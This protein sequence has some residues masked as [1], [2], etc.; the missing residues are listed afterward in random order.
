MSFDKNIFQVLSHYSG[1]CENLELTLVLM[2]DSKQVGELITF[3][4]GL[5]VDLRQY[6]ALD[7]PASVTVNGVE[8]SPASPSNSQG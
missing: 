2:S 8:E 4:D 1:K 5:N 7:A 6:P 3:M